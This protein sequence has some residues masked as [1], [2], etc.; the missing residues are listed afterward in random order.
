[1]RR[2]GIA[3]GVVHAQAE[4]TH[5]RARQK[6]KQKGR[7]TDSHEPGPVE[8]HANYDHTGSQHQQPAPAAEVIAQGMDQILAQ[9]RLAGPC[10]I[11]VFQFLL[12]K[13]FDCHGF[14]AAMA[15]ERLSA[16]CGDLSG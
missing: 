9:R 15:D 6:R 12:L 11:G 14:A 4:R 8:R 1:M 13:A 7:D 2:T 5:R 3:L 16:V 10:G